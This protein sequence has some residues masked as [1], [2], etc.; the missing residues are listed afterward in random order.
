MML[1]EVAEVIGTVVRK[2]NRLEANRPDCIVR[3][4]LLIHSDLFRYEDAKEF[5][6]EQ[7][8]R[9]VRHRVREIIVK[10]NLLTEKAEFYLRIHGYDISW[11]D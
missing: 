7:S 5:V 9:D 11:M 4:A 10:D 8:K 6:A 1:L 2:V 3:S